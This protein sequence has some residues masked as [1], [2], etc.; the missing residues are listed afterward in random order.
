M[1]RVKIDEN[2]L[3]QTTSFIQPIQKFEPLQDAETASGKKFLEVA[4]RKVVPFLF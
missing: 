3:G 1:A 2:L 4:N